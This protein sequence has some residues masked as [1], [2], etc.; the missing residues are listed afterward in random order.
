MHYSIFDEEAFSRR[1][2]FWRWANSEVLPP[3][4]GVLVL[5][6]GLLLQWF[7]GFV[8][9]YSFSRGFAEPPVEARPA[10][11]E[12]ICLKAVTTVLVKKQA[13]R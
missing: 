13:T 9:L 3:L 5:V 2:R 1:E 4:R 11:N 8:Y 10:T 12:T 6:L 7:C